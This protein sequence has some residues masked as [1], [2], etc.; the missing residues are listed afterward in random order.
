MS[1][2]PRQSVT[3]AELLKL[4]KTYPRRW[5]IPVVACSVLAAAYALVRPAIWEASQA[6]TVR[7]EAAGGERPGKFHLVDDMK[8]VQET[9]LELSKSHSVLAASLKEAG[10]P[11]NR[12]DDSSWPT[13]HDVT[14]LQGAVKLSP[15]HGAEF[16]KT[17]VFY[18]QVQ[19]KERQRAIAL[20]AA[21]SNQ[22]KHRF[23]DLRDSKAQSM[24]NELTKSVTLAQAEL[25][26]AS[27]QLTHMDAEVGSDLGELRTLADATVGDSPLR[28]SMTEMETE[29]RVAAAAN[30]ANKELLHLLQQ[31]QADPKPL[32][33]APSR[34]LE[35]QPALR[36][37]KESLVDAQVHTAQLLG[38]LDPHHPQVQA[39]KNAEEE[40]ARQ[41]R[42]EVKDAIGS[43][44]MDLNLSADRC[45]TLEKQLAA[46]KQRLDRLAAIRADY[47][48]LVAEVHRRSDTLKTAENQ[49]AEA[50]A[51]QASAHA[52][53]LISQIDA[54]ETGPSPIGLGNTAIV[55]LGVLGGV[56]LA[57]GILFLTVPSLQPQLHSFKDA[58]H[59][60]TLHPTSATGGYTP[61]AANGNSSRG[62][63]HAQ[64]TSGL[65]LEEATA[66]SSNG[67]GVDYGRRRTDRRD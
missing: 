29:L 40:I 67:N 1:H 13:D 5:F 48:N 8:T 20:A 42:A 36:K 61:A 10:P 66:A 46:A 47:A 22:L 63:K 62:R 35:A 2:S 14:A 56:L 30:N 44:T 11:D 60:I 3:A 34:L 45:A 55:F 16:G 12:Q 50:S 54:P 39:A 19:S 52:A 43:L 25:K 51:S 4:L 24:V 31:S 9:I 26:T 41:I 21:V 57:T 6:L 18:L 38:N 15:P 28:R 17:E 33:A 32:L 58:L 65:S 59:A 27:E 7:D 37:L 64:M 49:L 23:D 53:S